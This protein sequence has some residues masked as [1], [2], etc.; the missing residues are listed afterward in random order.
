MLDNGF[1]DILKKLTGQYWLREW[2]S[3][4]DRAMHEGTYEIERIVSRFELGSM[5]RMDLRETKTDF[6]SGREVSE[7][8]NWDDGL[9]IIGLNELIED[10]GCGGIKRISHCDKILTITRAS[11]EDFSKAT[12]SNWVTVGVDLSFEIFLKWKSSDLEDLTTLLQYLKFGNVGRI[13]QLWVKWSYLRT[14]EINLRG[15]RAVRTGMKFQGL[16]DSGSMQVIWDRISAKESRGMEGG[17][18]N[19]WRILSIG[20]IGVDLL[21][22]EEDSMGMRDNRGWRKCLFQNF[23]N[24]TKDFHS[25]MTKS[26][27]E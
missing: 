15:M 8:I 7:E 20:W 11:L 13:L 14:L 26:L 27:R 6:M 22:L 21:P 5:L 1:G 3:L 25:A 4:E 2:F 23:S 10:G 17:W 19:L 16:A 18:G 9:V 24:S 12:E